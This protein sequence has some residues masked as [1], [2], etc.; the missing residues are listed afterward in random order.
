MI[1]IYKYY[2]E[3]TGTRKREK[4]NKIQKDENYNF[5]DAV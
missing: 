5:R 3:I 4:T 1:F 2:Y